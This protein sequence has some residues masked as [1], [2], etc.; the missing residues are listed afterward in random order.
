M[1]SNRSGRRARRGSM[2]AVVA[3]MLVAMSGLA[4]ALLQTLRA[5]GAL[6]RRDREHAH[7]RCVA[8]AGLSTALFQLQRGQSGTLGTP[9]APL[10]WDKSHYFVTRENLTSD[11]VRLT[12]TG[13]DDRAAARQELVVRRL[14]GT[15][16]RFGAFGKE[17]VR[18]SSN[19]RL[20]SYNSTLGSYASQATSG[21]GSSQHAASNGDIGSNGNIT[22]EQNVKVWGDANP[23]PAHQ[24][25]ILGNASVSGSTAPAPE[26]VQLP[27]VSVPRY[28]GYG[29]LTVS[30]NSTLPASNRTYTNLTVNSNKTLTITGPAN[31]VISNLQLRSGARIDINASAGDVQLWVI[32]NFIM[33]ANTRLAPTDLDCRHLRL[34]L[35]SDN[36][37]NPEH[38]VELDRVEFDSNSKIYGTILAPNAA[39]VLQSNFELFG[40]ILA[41]SIDL[42]SNAFFHFDEALLGA[43]GGAASFVT[44]SWREV[45]LAD[46]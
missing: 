2:L 25:T 8:Q 9:G 41:R 44:I 18:M 15:V 3:V 31:V 20:D 7:A 29:S 28:T 23:G 35:L 26:V 32:D 22:L 6:Q 12:S 21:S 1:R 24:D 16:W 17:F 4:V 33:A 34:N 45:P 39:I 36:V 37:I 19:S 40:S 13:L 30:S 38:E 11:I 14:P 43:G 27:A 42:R 5:S 46:R 10:A